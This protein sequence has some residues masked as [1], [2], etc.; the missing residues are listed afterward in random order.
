MKEKLLDFFA[1][2]GTFLLCTGLTVLMLLPTS[3][4][5]LLNALL[6]GAIAGLATDLGVGIWLW[7]KKR[8]KKN[9]GQVMARYTH[10]VQ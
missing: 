3:F 2:F 7:W 9:Q 8:R 4:D 10:P 5:E 6:I 1:W